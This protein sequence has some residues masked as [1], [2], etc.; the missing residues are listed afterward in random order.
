MIRFLCRR[1]WPAI[2]LLVSACAASADV[3]VENLPDGNYRLSHPR[4][5]AQD[6]IFRRARELC[7]A[8][9]METARGARIDPGSG[10]VVIVM[11]I[12]CLK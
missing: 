11:D 9:I 4:L 3:V 7:P 6:A 1:I 12:H 10:D 5:G 8:G 2:A